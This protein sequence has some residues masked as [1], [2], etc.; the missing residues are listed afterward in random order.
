[1]GY[2]ADWG[3]VHLYYSDKLH[4]QWVASTCAVVL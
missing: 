3:I 2:M 4:G 1:M